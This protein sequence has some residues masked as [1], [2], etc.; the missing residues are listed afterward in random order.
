[1]KSNI[2]AV[3]MMIMLGFVQVL[4]IGA[5]RTLPCPVKCAIACLPSLED[6]PICYGVCLIKCNKV[7]ISAYNCIAKCGVNKTI[8]VT[9]DDRGDVTDVVDSCLRNCPNLEE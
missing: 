4:E 2:V 7:P 1:M 9:V 8:T 5:R 6:Y 3:L